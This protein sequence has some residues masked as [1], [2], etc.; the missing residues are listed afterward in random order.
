MVAGTMKVAR[1]SAPKSRKVSEAML[2]CS[3]NGAKIRKCLIS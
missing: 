1:D 3:A 2:R